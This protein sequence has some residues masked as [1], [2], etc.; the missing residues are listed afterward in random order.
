MNGTI[1]PLNTYQPIPLQT[2]PIQYADIHYDNIIRDIDTIKNR[3]SHLESK[4]TS[5]E[6][7]LLNIMNDHISRI[8]QLE[9]IVTTLT[10]KPES[11][12]IEKSLDNIPTHGATL[13]QRDDIVGL[14]L[15]DTMT[16]IR[17]I[18]KNISYYKT[19]GIKPEEREIMQ[20]NVTLLRQYRNE[21]KGK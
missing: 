7:Y 11:S 17:R 21:L 5:L 9:E 19:K 1:T 3:L 18:A 16:A 20:Q 8:K 12:T 4:Y 2:I 6:N 14:S 10:T 13:L 15:I